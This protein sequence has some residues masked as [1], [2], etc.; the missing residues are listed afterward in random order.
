MKLV[1]LQPSEKSSKRNTLIR[2][3]ATKKAI[4]GAGK[5]QY[6]H[7]ILT[8]PPRI[9]TLKHLRGENMAMRPWD[10][11]KDEDVGAEIARI[12]REI[13]EMEGEDG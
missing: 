7:L 6:H 11:M 1:F 8:P 12:Q 5:R 4:P 9:M 10:L 13:E 2:E 3:K